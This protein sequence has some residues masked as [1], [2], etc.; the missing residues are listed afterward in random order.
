[1]KCKCCGHEC[2]QSSL[3]SEKI[4]DEYFQ[5]TKYYKCEKCGVKHKVI[6]A[7]RRI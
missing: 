3:E 4:S 7:P 2:V 1:M 6:G 5:T